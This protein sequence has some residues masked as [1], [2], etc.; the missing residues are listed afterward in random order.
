[1]KISLSRDQILDALAAYI[2]EKK[3]IPGG[4]YI[5]VHTITHVDA[6]M[7]VTHMTVEVEQI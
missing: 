5:H 6:R 2:N 1:M 4:K 7:Q 3:L